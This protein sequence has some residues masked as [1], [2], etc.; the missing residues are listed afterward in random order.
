MHISIFSFYTTDSPDSEW[1]INLVRNKKFIN[2]FCVTYVCRIFSR[3]IVKVFTI[4]QGSRKVK[5]L[6]GYTGP[7]QG[8]KIGEGT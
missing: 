2:T 8:L 4:S 5:N 7:S 3:K 1:G 6:G